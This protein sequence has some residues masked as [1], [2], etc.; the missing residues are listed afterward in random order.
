MTVTIRSLVAEADLRLAVRGDPRGLD[1]VVGWVA[2]S[3]LPDPTPWVQG[4]E[5][6]LTS[7][8]WLREVPDRARTADEWAGR[9]ARSGA[10]VVGFGLEPWFTAV[11]AEIVEA[12]TRHRLTLLEV[13]PQTPFVAIDRRV[14]D[15]H[16]AEA[17]RREADIVRSQQRLASAARS[18]KSA[19]VRTLSRELGGWVVT[20]DAT[21]R[22]D[23]QAGELDGVDL[24]QIS[25][26]AGQAATEARRSLLAGDPAR[27]VY[28]VPVGDSDN[29]QGTL[30]VDGRSISAHAAQ[31][32]GLV[33]TAAA[34]MCVISPTTHGPIHEAILELLLA[35]EDAGARKICEA[36]GIRLSERLVAVSLGGPRAQQA[37]ARAVSLG[38][39]RLPAK[40]TTG[41]VVV[42][43]P[44]LVE[45]RLPRLIE[46]TGARAG[47]SAAHRPV[48]VHRAVQEATS[49]QR[50]TGDQ[51]R[52]ANYRNVSSPAL[53][54]LLAAEPTRQFAEELLAPLTGH[55][56]RDRLLASATAWVQ[57]HGRWDPA[58]A[59]LGIHR[60]T[61]R[62]RLGRLA[63]VVG[64]D[65][66][67]AY[68]RLAL[69][70]ALE[71]ITARET[72][73][74][75]TQRDRHV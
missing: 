68:D 11:P 1:Q 75:R 15:L 41:P 66:D 28:L 18:G 20:M 61:L 40:H 6:L 67:S 56:E 73:D 16:A 12:T 51:R 25:G 53:E 10:T 7:G 38:M 5:L 49:A 27:P 47:I 26:L 65:L 14:A 48:D 63:E 17:R 44:S 30:C 69:A 34:I 59:A 60:V 35:G 36:A 32:A 45:A 42:G 39:W 24:D 71:A 3:E 9:L 31:R 52:I 46:Q 58:A 33:G 21:H 8:M 19:L 70:M 54:S 62:G 22:V 50:L 29:R 74:D 37:M 64:L 55:P 57:S 2:V 23:D 13:P 43:E 72:E 4:A